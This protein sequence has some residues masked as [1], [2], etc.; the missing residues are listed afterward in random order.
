MLS[1]SN[2]VKAVLGVFNGDL[3]SSVNSPIESALGI[4]VNNIYLEYGWKM[5]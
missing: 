4:K 3:K 1:A 5:S 2:A